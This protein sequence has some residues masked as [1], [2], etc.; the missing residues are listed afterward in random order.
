[1]EISL[2]VF[3]CCFQFTT[4]KDKNAKYREQMTF[5]ILTDMEIIS[6]CFK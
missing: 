5:L 4:I 2:T 3:F 6:L 1:M